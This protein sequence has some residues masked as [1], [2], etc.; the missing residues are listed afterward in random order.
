M[1]F[2]LNH[3]DEG[4]KNIVI[5][6]EGVPYE[7]DSN[8]PW[9]DEIVYGAFDDDPRVLDLIPIRSV[10]QPSQEI[11]IDDNEAELIEALDVFHV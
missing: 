9:W 7:A 10:Q 3:P 4:T 11:E 5:L 8:H 6:F 1:E 2:V